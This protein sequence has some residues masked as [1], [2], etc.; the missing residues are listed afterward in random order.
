LRDF[1]K[2][3]ITAGIFFVAYTLNDVADRAA[4]PLVF[5]FNGGPGSAS[6]WLHMGAIGPKRVRMQDKGWLP[7]PPYRLEDNQHTWL[8]LADLVFIDPVGTGYSRAVDPE[9]KKEF[10]GLDQDLKA[11]GEFIRL[12]LSRYQR[13]TSPLFLAGESYGTTRAAGL[14]NHLYDRGIAFNGLALIS[15]VLNFQT[16]EF[17][18][19]NDLPFILFLPTYAA[20]AWYHQRLAADLQARSIEDFLTE[21]EAWAENE[22][23]TALARGDRLSDKERTALYKR[24]ARYTG[25]DLRFIERTN[26]RIRDQH[27]YKELLRDQ[28]RTVGR[29][30]SRFVGIDK[31]GVTDSPEHDPAMTALFPPYN[32]TFN[33]Y[34]RADLGYDTDL[35]YEILSFDVNM[36][37]QWNPGSFPD[38][39]E[40]L[41]AALSKNP[42]MKVFVA[43]GYYDLATPHFGA[44]YTLSHMEL[45]PSLRDNFTLAYYEA[46]HM[47]YLDITELA[48]FK[49]DV[50]QFVAG[51]LG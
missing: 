13:W 39:S 20:T 40:P 4:R 34:V 41:R 30:D 47:L 5:V 16:L 22:Y 14:A 28:R 27:F 43:A 12:Y 18:T 50:N 35:N 48:K 51:A 2:D 26:G 6:V 44:E 19:G 15:T 11:V 31:L 46:G 17:T 42:F 49:A 33:Q 7:A 37:W 25:L 36:G 3:E 21:V 24:L 1:D 29:L 23:A 8:D 9:K 32:A 45:D 10:W 38:T